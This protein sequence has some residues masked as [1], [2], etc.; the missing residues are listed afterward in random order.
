MTVGRKSKI[1]KA[2]KVEQKVAVEAQLGEI[3]TR[4]GHYEEARNFRCPDAAIWELELFDG[5]VVRACDVHCDV[6]KKRKQVKRRRLLSL[7][8]NKPTIVPLT[9]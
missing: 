6:L 2:R 7:M 5:N 1:K 3:E 9:S 4:C 8:S